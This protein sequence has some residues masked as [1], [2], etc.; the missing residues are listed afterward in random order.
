MA[1]TTGGVGAWRVPRYYGKGMVLI[2]DDFSKQRQRWAVVSLQRELI[3]LKYLDAD[4]NALDGGFGVK[5]DTAARQF[6]STEKLVVD[7]LVGPATARRLFMPVTAQWQ[8]KFDIPNNLL[9]GMI[10]LES[11]VDPGC[12]GTVVAADRGIAQFNRDAWPGIDD[13]TAFGNAAWCIE[14]A[15]TGLAT[16]FSRYAS[17]DVAIASHN[18]PAKAQAWYRTGKAPDDQIRDY[19]NK[20]RENAALP[21]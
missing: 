19:V 2:G 16:N 6:Q 11:A 14:R 20:V 3:R 9:Y 17:W 1:E 10:R 21:I 13:A 5:T 12:E 4:P 18:N 15:A 7:G 8:R